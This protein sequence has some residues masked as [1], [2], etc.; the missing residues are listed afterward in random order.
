M[1][2]KKATTKKL[3]KTTP[4]DKKS[5]NNSATAANTYGR[6]CLPTGSLTGFDDAYIPMGSKKMKAQ[7]Q[8]RHQEV[9]ESQVMT[10]TI[11]D[12]FGS[13]STVAAAIREK[14]KVDMQRA[15]MDMHNLVVNALMQVGD[16][17]RAREVVD[18]MMTKIKTNECDVEESKC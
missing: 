8:K 6:S 11:K 5:V 16:T 9:N 7:N 10:W 12:M 1:S 15:Q 4:V 18:V 14:A 2:K 3:T 17:A 13:S